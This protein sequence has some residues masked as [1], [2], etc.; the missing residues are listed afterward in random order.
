MCTGICFR[1][2][3]T[4]PGCQ[5]VGFPRAWS[6]QHHDGAIDAVNGGALR[7]VEAI[8]FSLE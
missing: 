5:E 8:E 4:D 3:V 1:Q 2:D 6:G 7:R